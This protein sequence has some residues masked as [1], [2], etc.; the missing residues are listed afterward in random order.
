MDVGKLVVAPKAA[1]LPKVIGEGLFDNPAAAAGDGRVASED[2]VFC[3][4]G[5]AAALIAGGCC[6]ELD[7]EPPNNDEDG[8]LPKFVVA[9]AGAVENE[10]SDVADGMDF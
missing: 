3:D 8:P 1:A 10:N 9:T 7:I 4:C 2:S 6:D 5:V